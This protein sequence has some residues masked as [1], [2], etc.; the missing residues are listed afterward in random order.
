MGICYQKIYRRV[1]QLKLDPLTPPPPLPETE[2]GSAN[3]VSTALIPYPLIHRFHP[4]GIDVSH[5]FVD[6]SSRCIRRSSTIARN[7]RFSYRR[8]VFISV[9]LHLMLSERSRRERLLE[10]LLFR[11][12]PD[13]WYRFSPSSPE[14]EDLQSWNPS[15]EGALNIVTDI[16]KLFEVLTIN[17]FLAFQLNV[18]MVVTFFVI[19]S[20]YAIFSIVTLY[21]PEIPA[22]W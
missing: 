14:P 9:I 2:G 18:L 4:S 12:R 15:A 3:E 19:W 20:P 6:R 11:R 22:F 7:R 21:N 1:S 10:P 5:R 17:L 8:F 16:K 13:V